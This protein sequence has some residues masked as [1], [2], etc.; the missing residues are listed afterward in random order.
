VSV[1]PE[2]APARL[3]RCFA[4]GASNPLL[5]GVVRLECRSCHKPIDLDHYKIEGT[6]SRLIATH[7]NVVIE[8]ESRYHGPRLVCTRLEVKG[9][10]DAPFQCEEL[11]LSR[12]ASISAAGFA[13][14]VTV[15]TGARAHI[16][17]PLTARH[18]TLRGQLNVPSLRVEGRLVVCKGVQLACPLHVRS[19]LIEAGARYE[20]DVTI[21]APHDSAALGLP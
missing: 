7:G 20:G 14:E 21:L 4:C 19:L 11:I 1:V 12:N 3:I 13:S 8:R 9:S 2:S 10:L 6:V 5:D 16:A 17:K 18:V 15:E